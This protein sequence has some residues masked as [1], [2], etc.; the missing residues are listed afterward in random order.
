MISF[1][2]KRISKDTK[3]KI[4]ITNHENKNY[5]NRVGKMTEINNDH[6]PA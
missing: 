4:R 3:A 2:P 1:L 5:K 6:K